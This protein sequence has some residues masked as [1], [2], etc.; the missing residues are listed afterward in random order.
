MDL[1]QLDLN[2]VT[3]FVAVVEQRSFRA[4]ARELNVPKS[5]VSRRVALLEEQLSVQLLQRTTRTVTLTDVGEGFYQR[6][7]QALST[8]SDAARE[9]QES[10]A[11]PRGVLR[12]TAPVTFAEHFLG[13]IVTE[14]LRTNPEVRVTLDLTD[15][16]V[17]LVAEGY[18]LALRAGVLQDSTLR[19]RLLGTSSVVVVASPRYLEAHGAPETPGDLLEHDCIVNANS[20]RGAKW[21]LLVKRRVTMM[22]VR[23]RV[24]VSSFMLVRDFAAAGLGIARLPAGF[25]ADDE[26]DGTLVRVLEPYQPPPLPLH[27]V[28]PPGP[29]LSPRVRAFVDLLAARLD[30]NQRI[31]R[32]RAPA[33]GA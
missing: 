1:S 9:V 28:F 19:A 7:Q 10:E 14:F 25:S 33:R 6:A 20:E 3:A 24:A 29:R 31:P 15:R 22:P 11:S 21:P 26:A 8:L 16:Y 2:A 23:A 5:T 12:L 18:D 30:A 27:A 17:D 4:A 13:D 32:R